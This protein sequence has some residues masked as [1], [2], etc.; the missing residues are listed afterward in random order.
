[1]VISK[2]T[3]KKSG[4]DS[5]PKK[6]KSGGRS[7]GGRGSPGLIQCTQC[8]RTVPRDKAKKVTKYTSFVDYQMQKELRQ[9]GAQIPKQ[10]SIKY[11]CVSCAVHRRVVRVRAKDD[12]KKKIT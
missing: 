6:R 10:Q 5:I 2:S 9:Q 1:M 7:G 3:H 4:S 11:Y 12:R 8:G